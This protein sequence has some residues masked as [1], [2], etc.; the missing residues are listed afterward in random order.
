MQTSVRILNASEWLS[1]AEFL[2]LHNQPPAL[3]LHTH[4]GDTPAAYRVDLAEL[5]YNEAIFVV[6]EQGKERVGVMG[7]EFSADSA[8]A[9]LRGPVIDRSVGDGE[10]IRDALWAQLKL[11]LPTSIKRKDG[12]PDIANAVLRTWYGRHGFI[13]QA[14][15]F[16]YEAKRPVVPPSMPDGVCAAN[17]SHH[18]SLVELAQLVFPTGYLTAAELVAPNN[19][20]HAIFVIAERDRVDGYVYGNITERDDRNLEVYVDYLVVRPGAR[21][22]GYGRT[23]L[24]AI[25]AWGFNER[26]A[27]AVALSVAADNTNARGLY[28]SVGFELFAT[29][30]PMRKDT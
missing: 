4:S 7:A 19:E 11:A 29:G 8:R 23:L 9:W 17:E 30:V 3:C 10:A 24:Q 2:H 18:A 5:P 12:F 28:A 22:R 26:G 25:L 27:N 20:K 14:H 1:L 16:I 15:Y 6:A 13:A 21:G